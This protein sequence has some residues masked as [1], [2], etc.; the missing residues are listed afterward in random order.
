VA[1]AGS[2]ESLRAALALWRGQPLAGIDGEWAG[3][4]REIWSRERVDT[5]VR[6]ARAELAQANPGPVLAGLAELVSDNPL[7]ESLTEVLM[8]AL[9][10]AGRTSEA[11]DLYARTRRHLAEQLGTDPGHE[12]QRLHQSLLRG[13]AAVVPSPGPSRPG[14]RQ[15]PAPPQLFTGRV[16]ELAELNKIDDASTVVIT[17]IDGMAGVGKTALV[18]QAAH[19]MADRYPDGQLFIDLHGYTAGAAPVGPGEALD[20]MLR[21]LGVA[22][23]RIPAGL[24]QR[25]ALYRSRLAEQR[26]VIV[27]DNA[28]SEAQV[29]PLLPGAP[30]CVVW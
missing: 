18:V 17:A 10:A 27:L 20:W 1:P 28:A 16:M 30:G 23:D 14:P 25:A 5:A 9:H 4:M 21:S 6:W 19:Q 2:V 3:R 7:V 11:L 26:M 24:D 13:E 22:G 12:L 8:L 29:K 15:L